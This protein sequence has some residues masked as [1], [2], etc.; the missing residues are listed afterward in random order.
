MFLKKQTMSV[1]NKS[2]QQ[3]D[4]TASLVITGISDVAVTCKKSEPFVGKGRILVGLSLDVRHQIRNKLMHEIPG[5]TDQ[6]KTRRDRYLL[7]GGAVQHASA[8]VMS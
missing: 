7:N 8:G 5:K 4:A 2:P 3:E 1:P 6:Q